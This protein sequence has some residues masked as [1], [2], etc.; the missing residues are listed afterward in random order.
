MAGEV[1]HAKETAGGKSPIAAVAVGLI[2][3]LAVA[4]LALLIISAAAVFYDI[5][6]HV[7]NILII[8]ISAVS[9]FVAGLKAAAKNQ[10]NGLLIGVVTGLLYSAITLA[11]GLLFGSSIGFSPEFI[12]DF[13]VAAALGGLGGVAGINMA[14]HKNRKRKHK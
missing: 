4:V 8:V 13:A 12:A 3:G 7:M 2:F 9:M 14:G 11:A 10:K 5:P 6:E 1:I